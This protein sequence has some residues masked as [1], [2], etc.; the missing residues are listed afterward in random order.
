VRNTKFQLDRA[1]WEAGDH[2]P[3][4]VTALEPCLPLFGL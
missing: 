3:V 4:E 2:R 1:T